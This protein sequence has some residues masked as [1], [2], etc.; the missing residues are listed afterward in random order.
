[1]HVFRSHAEAAGQV[2]GCSVAIGN[3]DGVHNGHRTLI[4]ATATVAHRGPL[5]V[6]TFDPHP[7]KLL[8]PDLAPQ[9]IMPLHRRLNFLEACG[10]EVA[11]VEPFTLE[12]AALPAAEFVERMLIRAL[13]PDAVTVGHDFTYGAQRSGNVESLHA[14]LS[15]A[16]VEARVLAAIRTEGV[17][18]S[19][20][21]V[22]EFVLMGQMDGAA[23]LLGRAFSVW[24][25]V[26][27]GAGRGANLGIRTLNLDTDHEL[28]PRR[29]VYACSTVLPGRETPAMA[30]TNVGRNPTFGDEELH[31]ETHVLEDI[32]DQ[33][34]QDVEV[35]FVARLR[36]ERRFP[37]AAEL[38]RQIEEDI[39]QARQILGS[40]RSPDSPA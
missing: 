32:P 40:T 8:K 39:A 4:Q 35:R 12:L 26:V 21:K 37:G 15:A 2:D 7:A 5:T 10:V 27:H 16:G 11:V 22:R 34:G 30:V 38:I 28:L 20:T 9:L 36:D 17:I 19:S 1:M 6:L 33:Y 13:C 18:V 3:F 29:G 23:L 31:I 25:R 14:Q 24:G